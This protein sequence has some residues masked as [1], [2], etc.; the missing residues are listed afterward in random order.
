LNPSE[1]SSVTPFKRMDGEPVFDEAWQAQLLAMVDQM[2]SNGVFS[3]ALWSDTLGQNLKDAEA[4]GKAD[5]I[6]TYY[7]AVLAAFETLLA[8]SSDIS[9]EKITDKQ[10]A[11]ERAYLSTP[12]GQPVHLK[13]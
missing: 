13:E 1:P 2:M 11:W 9:T 4:R 7:A 3:N 8:Q 12:H 5:D 10:Q 6:D